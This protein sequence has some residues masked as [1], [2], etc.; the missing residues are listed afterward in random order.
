MDMKAAL[1]MLAQ[2][3]LTRLLVEGGSRLAATL[4]QGRLVD[5]I[6]WFRS[7]SIIGGDGTPAIAALGVETLDKA[8]LLV[9]RGM[10]ALGDDM[11]SSYLVS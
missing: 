7:G 8:P 3:G 5:R 9:L 6:E 4:M 10:Q 2:R 1:K 11:L